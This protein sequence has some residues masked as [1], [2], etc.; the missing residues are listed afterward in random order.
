M[1]S[2][3]RTGPDPVV[4]HALIATAP[5]RCEQA[6]DASRRASETVQACLPFPAPEARY[7]QMMHERSAE[8]GTYQ[9]AFFILLVTT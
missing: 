5:E 4:A 3:A 9:G 8:N 2:I 6:T 7:P 1:R